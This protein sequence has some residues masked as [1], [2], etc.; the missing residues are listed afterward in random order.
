[1]RI[2]IHS[3]I[4][5]DEIHN[6]ETEERPDGGVDRLIE[7]MDEAKLDKVVLLAMDVTL[8]GQRLKPYYMY[9]NYVSRL[10]N[11]YPDRFIGFAGIDPRRGDE[12]VKELDRC[13]NE[14]GLTGIKLWPLAGFYP[15]D[16]AYY[17][18]YE[19]AQEYK[20]PIL[21]HVGVGP[22]YSYMK[23]CRPAFVDRVAVDFPEL[24]FILPHGGMPWVDEAAYVAMKNPNVYLDLSAWQMHIDEY[25]AYLVRMVG[26]LI[27]IC[28]SDKILWGT[29]WPLFNHVISTKDWWEKV[30]SLETSDLMKRLGVPE[31]TSEDKRKIL[32]DNAAKI[33][34]L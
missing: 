34:N 1:M 16:P 5:D 14:L 4:W 13:I 10:V 3:H 32:G 33:L 11:E 28:G 7:D 18:F 21:C 12:A 20:T 19:R 8:F 31:I 30:D 17:P 23:Y 27:R 24:K 25:D 6:F 22:S 29:D 15:D 26:R 9:N 2:D